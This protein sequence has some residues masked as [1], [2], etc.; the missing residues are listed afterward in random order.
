MRS[1]QSWLLFCLLYSC[2]TNEARQSRVQDEEFDDFYNHFHNDSIFQIA[3]VQFPLDG[4]S[5][6]LHEAS[7]GSND[8]TL[9]AENKVNI[10]WEKKKLENSPL[11][12]RH[13]YL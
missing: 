12:T 8:T 4:F 6:E 3:R 1:F 7:I 9:I 10:K 5:S 11:T 2:G 13:F